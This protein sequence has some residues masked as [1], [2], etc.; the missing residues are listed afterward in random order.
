[1]LKVQLEKVSCSCADVLRANSAAEQSWGAD[2]DQSPP[3]APG[4]SPPGWGAELPPAAPAAGL[5][6]SVSGTPLSGGRKE[7]NP[8]AGRQR[9][10]AAR[11]CPAPAPRPRPAELRQ[12]GGL[13]EGQGREGRSQ[14]LPARC[15]PSRLFW[16]VPSKS[17]RGRGLRGRLADPAPAPK[18]RRPALPQKCGTDCELGPLLTLGELGVARGE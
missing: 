10:R 12:V 5:A 14:R 7:R 9:M 15:L 18:P 16:L 6:W 2:R 11:L 8:T 3:R 4:Q 1:M 17:R 13:R